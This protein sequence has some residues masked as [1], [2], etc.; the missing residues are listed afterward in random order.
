MSRASRDFVIK[1]YAELLDN[2]VFVPK[3]FEPHDNLIEMK[4]RRCQRSL[5]VDLEGEVLGS[6]YKN[7]CMGAPTEEKKDEQGEQ[8]VAG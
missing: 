2:H 6:A 8:Q 5:F 3:I 7:V 1:H 4:C